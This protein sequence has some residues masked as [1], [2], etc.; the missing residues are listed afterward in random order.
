MPTLSRNII[1]SVVLAIAAAGALIAYTSQVRN[2]ASV[3]NDAVR[4]VV[5]THDIP[6]STKVDDA[7][8]DG[9]LAYHTVRQ[10]DLANG[11]VT[12]LA[13]V[14][15]RNQVITQALYQGDQLTTN[16]SG[17]ATTQSFSYQV[18]GNFRLIRVPF[19]PNSGLLADVHEGDHVD[20]MTSYQKGDVTYTYL[21]VPDALVRQ[22]TLPGDGS[23]TNTGGLGSL[24]LQVTE[25]QTLAL[26]NALASSGGGQGSHAIYAA[27]VGRNGATYVPF[28][29]VVLPGEFPNH[30]LPASTR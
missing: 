23:V 15:G 22:V 20:V 3:G 4:V 6:A 1:I 21:T 7:I 14:Q 27:L 19:D 18:T 5:A 8:N 17:A 25:R 16:R 28:P 30:G 12:D 26:A 13:A 29:P 11:A 24:L 10:S 2:S 9:Y